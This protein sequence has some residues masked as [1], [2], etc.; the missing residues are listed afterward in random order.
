MEPPPSPAGESYANTAV[1]MKLATGVFNADL[2]GVAL[3][4]VFA[5][6]RDK[7][8]VNIHVKWNLLQTVGIEKDTPVTVRLKNVTFRKALRTIL[9]DAGGVKPLD[10]IVDGGVV[11]I[12]TKDDLSSSAYVRTIVYDI[13]DLVDWTDR[14]E[15]QD[16]MALIQENVDPA[17]WRP[18][19]EIAA[20]RDISGTLVITQT[21]KNHEAIQELF[22]NIRATQVARPATPRSRARRADVQIKL[23][24]TMKETCFDPAAMSLIAIAGLRDEVPRKPDD[25]IQELQAQLQRAGT[26]GVRNAIR[27]AL[28]D[29]YKRQGQDEKVLGTLR[30]MLR[31]NDEALKKR[32]A[33]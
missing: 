27:L 15:V 26:I 19:G 24:G 1:R 12:S 6:L 32:K 11:T 14:V 28:K 4:H 8:G 5:F 3:E 22:A 29:L 21:V 16:L 18:T 17:S 25:I 9:D 23:V 2:T 10:Y 30:D 7:L 20:V 33:Q 13:R 31:D